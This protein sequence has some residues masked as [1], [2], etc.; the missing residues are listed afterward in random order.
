MDD[1][2][3]LDRAELFDL[4]RR[5]SFVVTIM[6]RIEAGEPVSPSYAAML[7]QLS[8]WLL[9]FLADL[10]MEPAPC[11]SPTGETATTPGVS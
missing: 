5:L 11:M 10:L 4:A 2:R 6:E 1:G 9:E 3:D 8:P 7:T